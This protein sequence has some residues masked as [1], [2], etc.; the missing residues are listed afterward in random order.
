VGEVAVHLEDV[1]GARRERAREAGDVR[2][3]EPR[4]G[5]AVEHLDARIGGREPVGDLA[6]PVG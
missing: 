4:L 3:P 2:L 6:R 5:G 1:A